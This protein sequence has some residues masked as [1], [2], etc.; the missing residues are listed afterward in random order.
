M[1]RQKYNDELLI[2]I[3]S[4]VI[5]SLETDYILLIDNNNNPGGK[6]WVNKEQQLNDN[7]LIASLLVA[8]STSL[9]TQVWFLACL[10]QSQL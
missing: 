7:I 8:Q 1:R 4:S 10:V 2:D 6:F 9:L 3:Q 5:V